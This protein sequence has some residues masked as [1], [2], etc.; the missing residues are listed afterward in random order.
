[1]NALDEGVVTMGISL[2]ELQMSN[3]Q[4]MTD[5]I[6]YGGI[7][8]MQRVV[9]LYAKHELIKASAPPFLKTILG[10]YFNNI[11]L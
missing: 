4:I 6:Q 10:T 2:F 7:D 9:P 11:D 1:M 8:Y 5:Y 3:I